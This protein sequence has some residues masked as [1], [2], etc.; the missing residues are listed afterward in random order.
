MTK[1]SFPDKNESITDFAQ[2]KKELETRGIFIERWETTIP[3]AADASADDILAAYQPELKALMTSGGYQSAD[4]ITV[5]PQ[6]EGLAAIRQKFLAEHTHSEDEVRYFIDGQGLFWFHLDGEVLS[7]QCTAGDLINVPANTPHWFD[8]G[9][10][11]F[12]KAI[13][14]FTSTDGWVARYTDSGVDRRYN[15]IYP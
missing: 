11:P 14:I 6:T 1:L 9:P 15:P 12:V 3:L 10:T 8:L 7:V 4:V 13:R 5:H 2:I